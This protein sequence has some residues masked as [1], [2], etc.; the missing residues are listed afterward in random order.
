MAKLDHPLVCK[1]VASFQDDACIYMLLTLIQGGEL[2][3]I[4]GGETMGAFLNWQQSFTQWVLQ[5]VSPTCIADTLHTATSSLRMYCWISMVTP[6]LWTWDLVCIS[7]KVGVRQ[8]VYV[9]QHAIL[10]SSQNCS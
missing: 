6:L 4:Q 9:L 5:K 3:I 10:F 8:D 7:I 1:L 2:L